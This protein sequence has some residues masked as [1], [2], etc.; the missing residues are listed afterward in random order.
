M[1]EKD[2]GNKSK[3]NYTPVTTGTEVGNKSGGEQNF[4]NA[5]ATPDPNAKPANVHGEGGSHPPQPQPKPA[6]INRN[7]DKEGW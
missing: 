3:G 2:Y 1:A 5:S 4:D 6:K 7:N